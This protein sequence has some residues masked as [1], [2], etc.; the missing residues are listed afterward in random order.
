M[1]GACR[2]INVPPRGYLTETSY[3]SG[4]ACERGYRAAGDDCVEVEVPENAHL[5]FSGNDWECDKPYSKRSD[6]CA[7]SSLGK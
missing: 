6:R 1:N 4:W 2:G 7:P 3:G 5:D